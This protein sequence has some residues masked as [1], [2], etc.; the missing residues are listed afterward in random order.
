MRLA[1]ACLCNLPPL[2]GANRGS[3]RGVGFPNLV[4]DDPRVGRHNHVEV[5]WIPK[6]LKALRIQSLSP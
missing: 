2:V 4:F 6:S 5:A 3:H 1:A